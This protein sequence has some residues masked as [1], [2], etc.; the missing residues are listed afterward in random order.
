MEATRF[1]YIYIAILHDH[2]VPRGKKRESRWGGG[3]ELPRAAVCDT[4]ILLGVV[5]VGENARAVAFSLFLYLR[6]TSHIGASGLN[7][8][9]LEEITSVLL[10]C[11]Q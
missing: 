3:G 4:R 1:K 11:T 7:F 8:L 5:C 6:T 9:P 2:Y 10:L